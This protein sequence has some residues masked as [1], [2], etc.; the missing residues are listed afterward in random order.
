MTSKRLFV[1]L[2]KEN[3]KRRLWTIALSI[4]ANFF[5]QIVYALLMFGHYNL[6]LESKQTN[7]GDIQIHFYNNIAGMG[8]VAVI[9]TILALSFILALQSYYYLFDSKQTDLYYSLP[10]KREKLFDANNISGIL[11][12]AV[13]YV[14]C[15]LITVIM[16]ISRGYVAVNSIFL[17]FASA[18]VMIVIFIMC[19]EICTLAA[20][21]TGHVVVA[22]L[23]CAVF[24]FAG[25]V[26]ISLYNLYMATFISSFYTEKALFEVL[27]YGDGSPIKLFMDT[28]AKFQGDAEHEIAFYTFDAAKGMLFIIVLTVL[29]F[30]VAR[31]LVKRRPAEAAGKAMAFYITKPVFKIF[32]TV[33]GALGA[34]IMMY[35]VSSTRSLGIFAFGIICGAVLI[36]FVIETIYEFDFKASLK[37]YGTLIASAVISSLIFVGFVFDIFGYETWQPMPSRV[38]SVAI[39]DSIVYEGLIAPYEKVTHDGGYYDSTINAGRYALANMKLTDLDKVEKITRLGAINA[40]EAHKDAIRNNLF[41]PDY[42]NYDYREYQEGESPNYVF[43]SVQW[44]LKNG[45]KVRRQYKIDIGDEE[46]FAAYKDLYNSE[47]YKEGKFPVFGIKAGEINSFNGETMLN[48]FSVKVSD[49][50][51]DEFLKIYGEELKNQSFDDLRKE[52]PSILLYGANEK[53]DGKYHSSNKY[54]FYIFPS[55]TKTIAFLNA[56]NVP[57][58]WWDGNE[59]VDNLRVIVDDWDYETDEP[60]HSEWS[61]NDKAE[62]QE[63]INNVIPQDLYDVNG[64]ES[65]DVEKA[66]GYVGINLEFNRGSSQ[67]SNYMILSKSDN[68]PD[69]LKTI[70]FSDDSNTDASAN[71]EYGW[72]KCVSNG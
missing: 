22:A 25:S 38:E 17:Y 42:L 28:I 6:R 11:I 41:S 5:S 31:F 36:H 50:E 53:G 29:S 21:L 52:N 39:A 71:S 2:L 7:I 32:I 40:R 58:S 68:L 37:N 27:L 49:K 61:S 48:D 34:G 54:N 56:H 30:A 46:L 60:S 45:K 24:F 13:P 4:A 9:L 33:V 14:I 1:N 8:N 66:A 51:M 15:H 16:G 12:F 44:N 20:V 26:V 55:F 10:V 67:Y 70:C 18:I 64:I 35:F 43:I 23:G 72:V 3:S 62:I 19:Y 63:V 47:E 69:K 57:A 59:N 65:F